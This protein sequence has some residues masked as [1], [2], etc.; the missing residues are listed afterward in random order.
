MSALRS[1]MGLTMF[2]PFGDACPVIIG[3][4]NVFLKIVEDASTVG[5][6]FMA[7][8]RDRF[9]GQ[10]GEWFGIAWHLGRP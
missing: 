7:A 5:A 10:L 4:Q 8:L 1:G 2:A 9:V 6:A 3:Q